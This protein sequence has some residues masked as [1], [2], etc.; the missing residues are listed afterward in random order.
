MMVS[1]PA[2]VPVGIH[3]VPLLFVHNPLCATPAMTAFEPRTADTIVRLPHSAGILTRWPVPSTHAGAAD[4]ATDTRT[5]QASAR[6]SNRRRRALVIRTHRI[7][8]ISGAGQSA[9]PPPAKLPRPNP[10]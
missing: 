7:G 1:D 9:E 10:A 6:M 3:V 8:D 2:P 4:T 5:E